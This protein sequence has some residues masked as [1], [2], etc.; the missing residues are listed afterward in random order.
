[1]SGWLAAGVVVLVLGV[2]I[3]VLL[4]KFGGYHE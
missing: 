3:V 1:M 4:H 2:G